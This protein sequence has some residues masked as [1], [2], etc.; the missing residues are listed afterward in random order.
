[1]RAI[2]QFLTGDESVQIGES[3]L[4]GGIGAPMTFTH[5]YLTLMVCLSGRAR[6]SLN[7]HEQAIRP[8]DV[9][10]LAEDTVA[11][12]RRRSRTFKVF[13][14]LM[15]KGFCTAVAY[16]LPNSLFKFLHD[17]PRCR[18]AEEDRGALAMWLTQIRQLAQDFPEYRHIMLRN[19][20]QNFF[21]A[22]AARMPGEQQEHRT[23]SRKEML[24]WRFWDLVGKH[25][26][27]HREV[28]FYARALSIT[29]YYLAQLTKD[30][31]NDTPKGLISRQVILEIKALLACSDFA[32]GR[33]AQ[34]MHFDDA[35]YLCRYFK[36]YTGFSLTAYRRQQHQ[37]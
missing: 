34:Q 17:Y 36:R 1:M 5:A 3:T 8:G 27:E 4:E 25:C 29:P 26:I 23:Y 24:S 16:P 7:F 10:V 11:V 9:L 31:F 19:H 2:P 12:L 33:I 28:G 37:L 6:F 32:I 22:I 20:L 21:L 14:C 35:S 30:F 13:F 18:P 15:P